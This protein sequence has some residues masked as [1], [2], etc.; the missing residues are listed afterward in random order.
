MN[1]DNLQTEMVKF[2]SPQEDEKKLLTMEMLE[3]AFPYDA[4]RPQQREAL[5]KIV[6]T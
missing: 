4:M 3:R 1:L 5:Q 6:D 2:E